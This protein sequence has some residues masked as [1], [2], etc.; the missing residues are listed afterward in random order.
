MQPGWKSVAGDHSS[1]GA[2]EVLVL[3]WQTIAVLV[4]CR[5]AR[6]CPNNI[7]ILNMCENQALDL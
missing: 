6:K 1:A 2:R 5:S 7:F 4:Q 3:H